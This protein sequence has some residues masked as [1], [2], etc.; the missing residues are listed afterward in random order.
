[1]RA[2]GH[3]E[4]TQRGRLFAVGSIEE[5]EAFAAE[6]GEDDLAKELVYMY[7]KIVASRQELEAIESS[8]YFTQR[9]NEAQLAETEARA[10]A[11][12][13]ARAISR[14]TALIKSGIDLD[15]ALEMLGEG[16]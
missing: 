14:L 2:R 1:M 9:L 6:L 10:E 8:P 12:G 13:E 11:R 7:D 16:S 15:T 3:R 5:A 4:S